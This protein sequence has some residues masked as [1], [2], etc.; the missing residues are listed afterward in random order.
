[1][2]S[3]CQVSR[4]YLERLRTGVPD[5]VHVDLLRNSFTLIVRFFRRPEFRIAFDAV[6]SGLLFR[7]FVL[8]P[9]HIPIFEPFSAI[10]HESV[11]FLYISMVSRPGIIEE[12]WDYSNVFVYYLIFS[13]EVLFE[14]LGFRPLHKVLLAT[15]LLIVANPSAATNL[16]Q[17]CTQA[18]NCLFKPAFHSYADLILEVLC[19]HD[20]FRPSLARILQAISP[21]LSS[22]SLVTAVKVLDAFQPSDDLAPIFLD[23]F[24]TIAQRRQ[25]PENGF[26]VALYQKSGVF[27]AMADVAKRGR[28]ALG[29]VLAFLSAARDVVRATKRSEIECRQL[30]QLFARLDI[31]QICPQTQAF[32]RKIRGDDGDVERS[33]GPWAD[34]L[35]AR[36]FGEDV[37]VL[38]GK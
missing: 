13:A 34:D 31:A 27:R 32:A 23:A 19:R 24:A 12:Y 20:V 8:S 5:P 35:G 4:A 36:L 3:V 10:S 26:L 30:A 21:Q 9:S 11:S 16:S 28:Q 29:V 25:P 14:Q 38:K 1:V 15:I 33:W 17:P 7:S 22:V 37:Q 18:F 6:D 2:E